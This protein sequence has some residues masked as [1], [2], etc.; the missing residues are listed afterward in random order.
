M[1]ID[2]M[3]RRLKALEGKSK[4]PLKTA[5]VTSQEEYDQ[6]RA[7]YPGHNLL[8]VRWKNVNITKRD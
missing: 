4:K 5:F 3:K 6:L 1:T 2:A 7:A 8:I